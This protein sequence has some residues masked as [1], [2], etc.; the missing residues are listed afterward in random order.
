VRA[1]VSRVDEEASDAAGD[2]VVVSFGVSNP[3]IGSL[4]RFDHPVPSFLAV[5][6]ARGLDASV[7]VE[8]TPAEGDRADYVV[9]CT[10]VSEN[11][12]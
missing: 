10:V 12:E 2:R 5:G 8:T 1:D 11:A 3:T 7:A 9:T 4:E 6:L